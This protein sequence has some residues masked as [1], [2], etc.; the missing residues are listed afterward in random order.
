MGI[1]TWI[2]QDYPP[3]KPPP[4]R[5]IWPSRASQTTCNLQPFQKPSSNYHGLAGWFAGPW[6][7][8]YPA[9]R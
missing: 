7:C 9:A 5:E 1:M 6:L 2:Y 8:P 4:P 3:P